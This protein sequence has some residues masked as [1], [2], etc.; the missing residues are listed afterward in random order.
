M[1]K[2]YTTLDGMITNQ[3]AVL[4]AAYDR[5]YSHGVVDG[6]ERKNS[7][8]STEKYNEGFRKGFMAGLD[9]AMEDIVQ[10]DKKAISHEVI[11]D[12]LN[13]IERLLHSGLGKQKSRIF[14]EIYRK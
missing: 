9:A 2:D 8:L 14:A 13:Y 12:A 1:R 10:S 5:G 7:E 4:K 3:A 6:E 11:Y